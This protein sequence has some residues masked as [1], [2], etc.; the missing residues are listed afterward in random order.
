MRGADE[1]TG[2]LFSYVDLEKRVLRPSGQFDNQF[3]ARAWC[4]AVR[5]ICDNCARFG[6]C[7]EPGVLSSPSCRAA[8]RPWSKSQRPRP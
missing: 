8:V 5:V 4:H 2:E 7:P 6:G 1:R 3:P